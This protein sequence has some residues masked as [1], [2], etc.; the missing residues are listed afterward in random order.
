MSNIANLE[1]DQGS[2]YIYTFTL[3]D[4]DNQPFD[5]T[6]FTARLQVRATY[7]ATSVLIDATT[8]NGKLIINNNSI[9][10]NLLPSDTSGIKFEAKDD[11]SLI[12]LFDL[13]IISPT[14]SVYKPAKGTFTIMRE[15]TR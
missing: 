5:L 3:T 12:C 14:G 1:V 2:T 11:D 7:G 13:E 9:V 6:G 15:I 10:F 4:V 8:V